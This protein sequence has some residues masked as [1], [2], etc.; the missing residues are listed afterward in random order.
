[1]RVAE[2]DCEISHSCR[3][4][5]RLLDTFI[6]LTEGELA[7]QETGGFVQESLQELLETLRI[8]RRTYG[9]MA[10]PVL[11]ARRTRIENAA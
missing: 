7:E 8:E 10:V 11:V 4:H 3:V 5:A 1:M 6:A 2:R 9:L